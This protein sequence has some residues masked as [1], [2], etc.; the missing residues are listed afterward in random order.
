MVKGNARGVAPTRGYLNCQQK[1]NEGSKWINASNFQKTRLGKEGLNKSLRHE[2]DVGA[3]KDVGEKKR[4]ALPRVP[5][6]G[7]TLDEWTQFHVKTGRH[8]EP[9]KHGEIRGG[10]K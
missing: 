4:Q 2:T 10:G 3:R 9:K 1:K 7:G 5:Q 8:N 6:Q